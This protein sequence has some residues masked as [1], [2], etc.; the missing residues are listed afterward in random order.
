MNR[1]F[2]MLMVVV[3]L[4]WG[5]PAQAQLFV[6][7]AKTNPSQRVPELIATV[8]TD[9]DERKRARAAEELRDYAAAFPDIVPVLADVLL[10]DKKQS[11]RL[12]ALGSLGKIRPVSAVAGQAIEKAA[13][14]DDVLRVRLQ[15]KATLTKYHLAG[16]SAK[17]NEKKTTTAEPPQSSALPAPRFEE[18]DMPRRMPPG[19]PLPA[20]G[21]SLFPK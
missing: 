4:A 6:K 19:S 14:Q 20:E 2:W 15:A 1:V 7:K 8:K 21:P 13:A 12:E 11:V 3:I 18:N 10:Q 5:S 9:T 16:Y 17:K